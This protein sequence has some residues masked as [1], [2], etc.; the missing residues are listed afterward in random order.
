MSSCL[1]CS[2]SVLRR[3]SEMCHL[4]PPLTPIPTHLTPFSSATFCLLSVSAHHS[5]PPSMTIS[6]LFK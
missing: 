3:K 5:F 2:I 6:P 1:V 4:Q